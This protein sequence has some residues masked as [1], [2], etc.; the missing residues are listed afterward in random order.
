MPSISMKGSSSITMR[1]AKVPLSPSSELQ[2]TY[3][4]SALVSATVFHLMP[5][6][7]PA[8]PRPRKP[9]FVISSTMGAADLD[10][11]LQTKPALMSGIIFERNRIGNA[12]T[13]EGEARLTLEIGMILRAADTQCVR[14]AVEE[15]GIEERCHIP[16]ETGP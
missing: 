3:L 9:D 7:K 11:A 1:S 16:A 2:T 10:G 8:P 14:A 15:I 5:V 13:S 4:R 6:G 12:A